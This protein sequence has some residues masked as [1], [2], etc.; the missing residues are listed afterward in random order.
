MQN[1]TQETARLLAAADMT[2]AELSALSATPLTAALGGGQA[3]G[4]SEA[5]LRSTVEQQGVLISDYRTEV[6]G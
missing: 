3:S 4:H 5:A 1:D 6:S 2:T